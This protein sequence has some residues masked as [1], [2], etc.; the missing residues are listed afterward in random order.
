MKNI[1]VQKV[2]QIGVNDN[3][4]RIVEWY[5]DEGEEVET[6]K[7][8]CQIETTKSIID[9]DAETDGFAVPLC[10][11]GEE[12][13]VSDPL[14]IIGKNLEELNIYKNKLS[15]QRQSAASHAIKG[16]SV[17]AKAK[18][19]AA[20]LGVDLDELVQSQ[21]GVIREVHVQEYFNSKNKKEN[22]V[23][24]KFNV[25]DNDQRTLMVVYGAGSGAANLAEAIDLQG[26]YKVACFVDDF[27]GDKLLHCGLPV[28]NAKY[29]DEIIR[30]GVVAIACGIAAS[31][32]RKRIMDISD[33][34]E[35]ELP[36]IIHPRAFVSTSAQIGRGCFIKAGAVIDSNCS[37][38]EMC[39]ID[40]GVT[41]AHDNRLSHCVHMAPMACTGGGVS[42]GHSTVVGIGAS[43]A[44]GVE[45]GSRCIISVGSSVTKN[46][47]DNS[48][49]EGVP[50]RVIGVRK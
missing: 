8:L 12:V 49:V 33:T 35:L 42:I 26:L 48:V 6:G 43:I 4:V 28:F 47:N 36:S 10:L 40:N 32:V 21:E 31:D 46:I 44:T 1:L 9:V 24:L 15:T 7:T 19:L 3:E 20:E 22:I 45:I 38:G 34:H 11:I 30:A 27:P 17:T 41:I 14:V 25:N 23:P 37:I 39:I 18:K 50:G 16:S 5:I 29:L 2:P 13:S